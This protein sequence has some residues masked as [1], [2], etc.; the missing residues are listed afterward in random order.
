M[1]HVYYIYIHIY[2]LIDKLTVT[3]F[4]FALPCIMNIHD[5]CVSLIC[6]TLCCHSQTGLDGGGSCQRYNAPR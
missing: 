6:F 1:I 4:S 3:N 2:V 5:I